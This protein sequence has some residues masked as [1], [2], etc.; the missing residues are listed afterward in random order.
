MRKRHGFCRT[1][2]ASREPFAQLS[3]RESSPYREPFAQLSYRASSPHRGLAL[4]SLTAQAPLTGDLRST[5]LPRKLPSPGTCAQLL[6]CPCRN[7]F[8]TRP[9]L[10][11]RRSSVAQGD[12]GTSAS[13]SLPARLRRPRRPGD[14]RSTFLPRKLHL[15]WTFAQEAPPTPHVFCK[16][17]IP[18]ELLLVV[19]QRCDS[20]RVGR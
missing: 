15:P 11:Y 6:V 9:R 10:S 5:L 8:A 1:R 2:R 12:P 7:G 16:D 13:T 3:Y 18:W 14:F 4:N 19:V 17:M 20:K